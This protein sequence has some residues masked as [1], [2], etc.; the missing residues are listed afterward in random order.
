MRHGL[1][2]ANLYAKFAGAGTPFYL[3]APSWGNHT[4][5]FKNAGLDVR[6]YRYYDADKSKGEVDFAG[7]VEDVRAAPK[8]SVFLW[9]ACAHNPTG[10]DLTMEQWRELSAEVMEA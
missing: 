5:I 8:G 3:P 9:H 1:I 4:P 2:G 6:T 10:I 7:L